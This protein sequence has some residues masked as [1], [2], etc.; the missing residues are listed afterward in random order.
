MKPKIRLAR[1]ARDGGGI[2]DERSKYLS[3]RCG[4]EHLGFC[5]QNETKDL[6]ICDQAMVTKLGKESCF[7][8][9]FLHTYGRVQ[10][11]V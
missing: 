4:R 5:E 8:R 11:Q 10:T 3:P 6:V 2:Q 1:S 9:L 7:A